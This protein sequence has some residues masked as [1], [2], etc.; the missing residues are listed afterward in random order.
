[1]FLIKVAK[2]SVKYL[3]PEDL[4]SPEHYRSGTEVC[5]VYFGIMRITSLLMLPL[6]EGGSCVLVKAAAS[7]CI[8]L[9]I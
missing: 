7:G 9:C 8:S 1:M 6:R 3:L 4:F 2:P 5:T